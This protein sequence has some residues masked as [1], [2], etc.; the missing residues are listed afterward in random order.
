MLRCMLASWLS[1]NVIKLGQGQANKV[2]GYIGQKN[3]VKG[4]IEIKSESHE[5]KL[6]QGQSPVRPIRLKVTFR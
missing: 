5:N 6:G 3:K 1:S 2:K 4:Y